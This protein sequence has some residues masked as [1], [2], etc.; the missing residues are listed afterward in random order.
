M[1]IL[2]IHFLEVSTPEP[3]QRRSG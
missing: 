1:L 2:K 3:P